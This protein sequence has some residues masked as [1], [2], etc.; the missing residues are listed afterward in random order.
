MAEPQIP[1][2]DLSPF[3]SQDEDD[4]GKKK[5]MEI[6]TKACSEYGFFQIVNHGVPVDLLQ[7]AL[8]L[9]SIFFDYPSQERLKIRAPPNAPLPVGYNIQ[10]QQSPEKNEYL[11]M[12][13][14]GSSFNVFPQ[15]PPSSIPVLEDVFSKL[16]KTAAVVEGIVNQCLGL[17][18]NFLREFNHDRNW[19]FM[20]ALRY[21]PATESENNGI[22]QHEDGNCLTLLFQ[23][24][25]GGLQVRKD[26]EWIPVIPAKHTLVVNLGDVIQV[27]NNNKFKSA[28]HR[29]VRPKERSR[30]S[31]AFFHN[32]K[33]DKWV[34]PLP[35]FTKDIGKP[36]KYRGF[37]YSEYQQLRVRNKTH[38]PSR[39][40]D[41]I[42]IT[43][44]EITS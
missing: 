10:P 24:G 44:Y 18:T 36:P 15:N 32:L 40:E 28:T 26:G 2:V 38:P 11:W 4:D 31:F 1:T 19:D 20:V 29:V 8:Q 41:Q 30:Y 17:P 42:G 9:S 37:R 7:R 39:P 34:E 43:H 27:L 14:P 33:G 16:T 12:F 21:F 35:H 13:P 5:A 6:I 23:D 25:T 22:T 3:F